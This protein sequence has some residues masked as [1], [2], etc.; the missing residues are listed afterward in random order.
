MDKDTFTKKLGLRVTE[1]RE[2]QKISQ[3]ELGRR[4][5]KHKQNISRL[6]AGDMNPSAYYL[7]ELSIGLKTP[8]HKILNFK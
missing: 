2:K 6:E 1:L 4:C 3:A 7:Y 5:N 8:L